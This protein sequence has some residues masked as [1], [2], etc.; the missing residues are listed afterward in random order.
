MSFSRRPRREP[1]FNEEND[2]ILALLY[3][4]TTNPD[5][6]K[7]ETRL[8]KIEANKMRPKRDYL[9]NFHTRQDRDETTSKILDETESLGTFS[10]KTETK[11]RLSPIS[12]AELG[13]KDFLCFPVCSF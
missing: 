12:G 4:K 11:P 3:L 13:N 10:L 1:S 6:D 2:L 5:Q 9:K 7:T 8:S